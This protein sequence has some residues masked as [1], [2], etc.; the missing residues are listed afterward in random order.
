MQS[1]SVYVLLDIAFNEQILVILNAFTNVMSLCVYLFS[2][3]CGMIFKSYFTSF[4]RKMPAV[5]LELCFI[6][7][8]EIDLW[9]YNDNGQLPEKN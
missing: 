1:D 6:N 5:W 8:L 2:F 9:K 4:M 7:L 3:L